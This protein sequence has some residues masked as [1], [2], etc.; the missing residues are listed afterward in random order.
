MIKGQIQLYSVCYNPPT[1]TYRRIW[2]PMISVAIY[3]SGAMGTLCV[4]IG[5]LRT[6]Y[7]ES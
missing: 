3:R 4:T 2:D 5:L 6:E 7:R 1:V